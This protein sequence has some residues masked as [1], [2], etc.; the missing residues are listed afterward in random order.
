MSRLGTTSPCGRVDSPDV[1][2]I[3]IIVF[4]DRPYSR[5]DKQQKNEP[6]RFKSRIVAIVFANSD[7][8]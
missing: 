6:G 3:V 1:T 7:M 8:S 4:V 5:V 2:V